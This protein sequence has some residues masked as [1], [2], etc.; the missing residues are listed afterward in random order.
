MHGSITGD[1]H[2]LEIFFRCKRRG[3]VRMGGK[4][5]SFCTGFDWVPLHELEARNFF[6][7]ALAGRLVND[8]AAGFKPHRNYLGD[9]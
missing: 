8:V 2:Q 6:P 3:E 1:T 7:R 4:I 9:A 5:D